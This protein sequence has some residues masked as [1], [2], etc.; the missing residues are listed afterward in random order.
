M[1]AW[2]RA[3][4][5]S[6]LCRSA[7]ALAAHAQVSEARAALR[8]WAEYATRRRLHRTSFATWACASCLRAP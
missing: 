8:D 2:R 3:T 6:V 7:E 5:S 1:R 4:A